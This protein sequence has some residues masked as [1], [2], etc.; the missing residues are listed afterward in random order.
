[1]PTSSKQATVSSNDHKATQ[2][3]RVKRSRLVELLRI[4]ER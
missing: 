3:R 4:V 1:M 2:N